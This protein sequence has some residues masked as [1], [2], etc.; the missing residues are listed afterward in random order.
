MEG[1]R[2]ERECVGERERDR[3]REGRESEVRL[4]RAF[5]SFCFYLFFFFEHILFFLSTFFFFFLFL[6][7]SDFV[8]FHFGPSILDFG[9]L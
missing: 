3:G 4:K 8:D 1:E 5:F 6:L 2:E 7:F 9:P